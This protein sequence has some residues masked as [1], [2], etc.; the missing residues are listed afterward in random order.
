ME[1][2]LAGW[3]LDSGP[4]PCFVAVAPSIPR[5]RRLAQSGASRVNL[6]LFPGAGY[7]VGGEKEQT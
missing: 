5:R 4:W 2:S 3:G 6:C 1:I 7:D